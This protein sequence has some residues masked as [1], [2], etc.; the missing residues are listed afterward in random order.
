MTHITVEPLHVADNHG[1]NFGAVV[2]NANIDNL[3]GKGYAMPLV[4]DA[5]C[6]MGEHP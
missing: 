3:T 6:E 5:L 4:I 1:V 2:H